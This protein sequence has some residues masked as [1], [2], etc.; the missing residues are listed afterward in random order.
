MKFFKNI[1]LI[2]TSLIVTFLVFELIIFRTILIA[3][4]IPMLYYENGIIKYLPNQ[5]GMYRVKNEIKSKFRINTNGWNSCHPIYRED[6]ATPKYRIAIIG[7][8]YVEALQVDFDK[9]FAAQLEKLLGAEKHEAFRFGISG[10]PMSQYLHLLRHEAKK[11]QP[12]LIIIVLVHNDF[13]ES[14]EYAAGV[15]TSSFLKIKIANGKV[16][17]EILP[18][19]YQ[20]QWY[21]PIR[22][23]SAT[24][25]YL[26]YRQKINFGALKGVI[27]NQKREKKKGEDL[28]QAN[29][30]L[31]DIIKNR[32]K[33]DLLVNYVFKN[34]KQYVDNTGADVII[35]MDGDRQSIYQGKDTKKLYE[36]GALNL[37]LLAK[38]SARKNELHFIDLHPIF[39]SAYH[40][41]GKKFEFQCDNH[42]NYY[43]HKTVANAIWQYMR[44]NNMR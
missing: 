11:Y 36:S 40:K 9:S 5:E 19:R 27:L 44:D 37:N 23:F 33:N 31:S 43:G 22:D 30:R 2:I 34:I 39:A 7:D 32:S 41:N 16:V 21:S 20:K 42:W 6:K 38:L 10:A 29:V 4:D 24:W 18:K 12:D 28:Y 14:Y 1:T 35:V 3:P 26:A 25:K 17:D 15:Y 13:N 8:S